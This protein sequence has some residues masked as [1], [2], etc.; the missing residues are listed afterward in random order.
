MLIHILTG[1]LVSNGGRSDSPSEPILISDII[2]NAFIYDPRTETESIKI[3]RAVLGRF[4]IVKQPCP[5]WYHRGCTNEKVFTPKS[6]LRR[7][8]SM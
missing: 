1:I 3:V 2:N 7:R 5:E 8:I 6:H 4:R